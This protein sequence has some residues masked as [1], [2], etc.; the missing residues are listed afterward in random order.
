MEFTIDKYVAYDYIKQLYKECDDNNLEPTWLEYLDEYISELRGENG[1][2]RF[3]SEKKLVS[4]QEFMKDLQSTQCKSTISKKIFN[5]YFESVTHK[6]I[7]DE[8]LL[9]IAKQLRRTSFYLA[10]GEEEKLK[11]VFYDSMPKLAY[12]FSNSTK[13]HNINTLLDM[14]IYNTDVKK[15]AKYGV[16]EETLKKKKK[17]MDTVS[18]K[19]YFFKCV[20]Y[21]FKELSN[22]EHIN[23]ATQ[24][25]QDIISNSLQFEGLGSKDALEMA[26]GYTK[27]EIT[28]EDF[29]RAISNEKF[30]SIFNSAKQ[31]DGLTNQILLY[32]SANIDNPNRHNQIK[33]LL[34]LGI[35]ANVHS[36]ELILTDEDIDFL[37]LSVD[38]AILADL[39]DFYIMLRNAQR[40]EIE[41]AKREKRE[42]LIKIFKD[43]EPDGKLIA[44]LDKLKKIKKEDK[45]SSIKTVL[46]Y[47]V[48][49]FI[50]SNENVLEHKDRVD[51]LSKM[52][53][54]GQ[55]LPKGRDI[56]IEEVDFL[57]TLPQIAIDNIEQFVAIRKQIEWS[58]EQ[59]ERDK[60]KLQ[61]K[62]EK[63]AEKERAKQEK[64]DEEQRLREERER[65]RQEIIKQ[66]E[67]AYRLKHED[68][69]FRTGDQHYVMMNIEIENLAQLIVDKMKAPRTLSPQ[70]NCYLFN[71]LDFHLSKSHSAE[72]LIAV[73]T[74][75]IKNFYKQAKT[76][77]FTKSQL[78][79]VLQFLY[80]ADK[81]SRPAQI[82]SQIQ[83]LVDGKPIPPTEEQVKF[84]K[85]FF[86]QNHIAMNEVNF[87]YALRRLIVGGDIESKFAVDCI[88][89]GTE[90]IASTD[91][92]Q[93]VDPLQPK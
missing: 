64:I 4:K 83:F 3:L 58:R 5:D 23:N 37:L 77:Q 90:D 50:K 85:D 88:S 63:V 26:I 12:L 35:Q 82:K 48:R 89:K 43:F 52:V 54:A 33:E 62:L 21:S 25:S 69:S 28:E 30:M 44:L 39:S 73:L 34:A 29:A 51:K 59:Q 16:T 57:L 10:K 41:K 36:S 8:L 15:W 27:Y 18:N 46:N 75:K 20:E 17:G 14:L 79:K 24:S 40:E 1:Y 76:S 80:S 74:Q 91:E 65:A 92:E 7:Y 93:E 11:S 6:Y 22:E 67:E 56:S 86:K 68:P 42:T 13:K 78:E 9:S 84:V 71:E 61:K 45:I 60:E 47:S 53:T 66:R 2:R 31:K 55:W 70:E 72:A 19:S 38:K 87:T 81:T 49:K 32:I